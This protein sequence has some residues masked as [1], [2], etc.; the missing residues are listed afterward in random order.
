MEDLDQFL[1]PYREAIADYELH[2]EKGDEFN[3]FHLIQNIYGISETKHSRFLTFLLNP[4]EK[5]H[6]QKDLYLKLFLEKLGIDY[7]VNDENREWIVEA[8]KNNA[9]ISL[10]S[11]Y[12]DKISVVIENKCFDAKDQRNQ[13]YRYWYYHIYNFFD[14][15]IIHSSNKD[16]CRIVYLPKGDWK[17]YDKDSINKIDENYPDI[18]TKIITSWTFY[19][20]ISSWLAECI[21]IE[22]QP[23]RMKYFI[24]D[25]KKYWDETETKNK[26]IISQMHKQFNNK[27][28]WEDF[29]ELANRKDE[30][31]IN[32]IEQF[33]IDLK[34][35]ENNLWF[36]FKLNSGD[37][38][39]YP[40]SPKDTWR[41]C[42]VYEYN[43]GISIWKEGISQ[44]KKKEI[45]TELQKVLNDVGEREFEFVETNFHGNET[46]IM[47]Y[48]KNDDMV[49]NNEDEFA[50][51]AG[52]TNLAE[53][54]SVILRKFLTPEV[55]DLFDKIDAE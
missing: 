52:N 15:S 9:D 42:F 22:K 2:C 29:V 34:K 17:V 37:L 47:K 28:Q 10:K 24:S 49:F 23:E 33:E 6:G 40:H 4:N 48:F 53:Q 7:E 32:W 25:Y 43:K 45:R 20:D 30:L 16:K 8:E 19:E 1:V 3:V 35:N 54:I 14:K 41:T 38:R 50:W 39:F 36:Y 46:Y 13:L 18:D 27:K 31:K 5:L 21:A 51:K 44:E 11:N 26:L 12:P 55:R